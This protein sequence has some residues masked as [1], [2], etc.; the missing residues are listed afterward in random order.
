MARRVEELN[1]LMEDHYSSVTLAQFKDLFFG[2]GREDNKP[3]MWSETLK[4]KL[5]SVSKMKDQPC[6]EALV[7]VS[8]VHDFSPTPTN[9]R[10]AMFST[11]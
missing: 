7:R 1:Y 2:P 11:R 3:R 6:Y 5:K 4:E 9:E 8:Y 10:S